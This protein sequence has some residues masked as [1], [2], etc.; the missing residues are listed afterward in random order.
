MGIHFRFRSDVYCL[1][2]LV[3][4]C[5]EIFLSNALQ[6]GNCRRRA[7][8]ADVSTSKRILRLCKMIFWCVILFLSLILSKI[9]IFSNF[10]DIWQNMS[11]SLSFLC[12]FPP[13]RHRRLPIKRK[14][15]SNFFFFFLSKIIFMP[16]FG[17]SKKVN[18]KQ[19]FEADPSFLERVLSLVI[20]NGHW[21]PE[22]PLIIFPNKIIKKNT[23]KTGVKIIFV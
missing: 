2:W 4:V 1:S 17:Q 8:P 21:K 18:W 22:N 7:V 5:R 3:C 10:R 19:C 11:P 9:C 16:N 12:S 14:Y 13:P 20:Q 15:V 6:T 23:C